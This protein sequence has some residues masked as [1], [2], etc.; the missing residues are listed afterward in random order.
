MYC[1]VKTAT[2][3]GIDSIMVTCESDVSNGLP[4][5]S[6]VGLLS[7]EVKESRERVRTAVKNSKIK[8][9]ASRITVNISPASIRKSG[10]GFDLPIAASI[11]GAMGQIPLKKLE[12]ILMIGEMNLTGEILPI[13]GV[14]SA[15][16]ICKENSIEYLMVPKENQNEATLIED[17][18]VIPVGSLREMID[19]LR[20]DFEL[21]HFVVYDAEKSIPEKI[22]YENNFKDLKGHHSLRRSL[23][24]AVSGMHNLLMIGPPGAGKTMA[25][26]MVPSILP[27]MTKEEM[28]EVSKVYSAAGL[29]VNQTSL[30][31]KR[32]FRAPHHTISNFGLVGGGQ[33]P[34]PG[35][36]TLASSGVLFLDE[37][38]EFRK[39]AL[40]LLRQPLE[41]H[42]I[43]ISRQK[44]QV[45]FP[46]DFMLIAAT[47]P[48]PCGYYP[49]LK[50]C[51]CKES[52][53]KRY[54]SHLSGP[55]MDR[56]DLMVSIHP[57]TIEEMTSD[58]KYESSEE[59]QARVLKALEKQKTRF[60]GTK[61]HFNSRIPSSEIKKYC[62]ISEELEEY[63]KS[64][65]SGQ[66]IS[67]RSYQKLLKISR[68]IADLDD[69]FN[70]EKKHLDEALNLITKGEI[71]QN[72]Y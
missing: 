34:V 4:N 21:E 71:W 23:E 28:I 59:I 69:S 72:M 10:T 57:L 18:K 64:H 24:I 12:S 26:S 13:K 61:I 22:I 67:V 35:E 32:P 68:T 36:I 8:F 54:L 46:A 37:L 42:K 16:I 65:L 53:I 38:F 31:N 55:L 15:S 14:L 62:S 66:T 27:P 33:N 47:N 19:I 17:V 9:P 30:I 25:A 58:Q 56:I 51:H 29:L 43:N 20:S 45:E 49:N 41:N 1:S 2:L 11:L 44:N 60:K 52:D 40:E 70:I 48:C 3:S 5:F 7:T 63:I 50:L 6:I 39:E